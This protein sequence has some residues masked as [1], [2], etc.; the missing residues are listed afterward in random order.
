MK[1]VEKRC[2]HCKGELS[3]NTD[4]KEVTCPYC[5]TK[6]EIDRDD[7]SNSKKNDLNPD[8]YNL[9]SNN[10]NKKVKVVIIIIGVVIFFIAMLIFLSVAGL[11]VAIPSRTNVIK[12]SRK[13]S[14]LTSIKNAISTSRMIINQGDLNVYDSSVSYYIPYSCIKNSESNSTSFKE[15]YVVVRMNNN[16]NEYY[17]ISKDN[18]NMS[19]PTLTSEQKLSEASIVSYTKD[20]DLSQ[21]IKGTTEIMVLDSNTCTTFEKKLDF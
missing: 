1:L 11:L 5:R 13:T 17:W 3:F 16:K 12:S 7:T 2:P 21:K 10:N 20:L 9:H 19:V 14:Y 4:S 6:Y 8:S 15:A 18:S